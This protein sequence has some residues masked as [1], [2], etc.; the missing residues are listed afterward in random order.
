[1]AES[2]F[3]DLMALYTG[4]LAGPRR[5]DLVEEL[6]DPE[7]DAAQTLARIQQIARGQIDVTKIPGLEE[8]AAWEARQEPRGEAG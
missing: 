7:S 4:S 8:I 6:H 2:L 3:D 5:R 1:M